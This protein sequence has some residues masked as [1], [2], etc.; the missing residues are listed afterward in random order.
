[1]ASSPGRNWKKPLNTGLA[2]IDEYLRCA[3]EER[4]KAEIALRNALLTIENARAL[5]ERFYAD[6][7]GKFYTHDLTLAQSV[8][9]ERVPVI[10]YG[11]RDL[12]SDDILERYPTLGSLLT[13]RPGRLESVTIEE[14]RLVLGI[15]MLEDDLFV[16]ARCYL[17]ERAVIL[18]MK[19]EAYLLRNGERHT[20][21]SVRHGL[22]LEA[23]SDYLIAQGTP[24]HLIDEAL[25]LIER[26][27]ER[28]PA[29]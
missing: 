22:P 9:H 3:E 21:T 10:S 19:Q 29:G 13:S 28:T 11:P 18:T 16:D 5:D 6:A 12:I 1:M 23:I 27:R 17:D 25:T 15:P 26:R 14:E 8:G 20:V 7:H 2:P 4:I 24:N